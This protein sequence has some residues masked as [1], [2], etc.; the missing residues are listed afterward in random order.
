MSILVKCLRSILTTVVSILRKESSKNESDKQVDLGV[1]T[2]SK[3]SGF[4]EPENTDSEDKRNPGESEISNGDYCN[5]PGNTAPQNNPNLRKSKDSVESGFSDTQEKLEWLSPEDKRKLQKNYLYLRENLTTL[6]V[7][8][9][10]VSKEVF[11]AVDEMEIKDKRV[12]EAKAELFLQKLVHSKPHS[13]TIF[14]NAL[15]D[16]EQEFIADKLESTSLNSLSEISV[17][18]SELR[19]ERIEKMLNKNTEYIVKELHPKNIIPYF[20]VHEIIEIEDIEDIVYK[21]RKDQARFLL[22]LI[23]RNLPQ[24]Y[25]VLLYSLQKTESESLARKLNAM[26][27]ETQTNTTGAPV[28]YIE[29]KIKFAQTENEHILMEYLKDHLNAHK[30]DELGKQLLQKTGCVFQEAVIGS[31]VLYLTPCS[32][33]SYAKLL[34]F[35]KDGRVEELLKTLLSTDRAKELLPK[36]RVS[37][38]IQLRA[39]SILKESKNKE[40]KCLRSRLI[41][42]FETAVDEIDPID[43]KD[44]FIKQA[45]LS[46]EYFHQLGLDL[47]HSRSAR[48]TD[49]L[50]KVL[51]LGDNAILAFKETVEK[52]GPEYLLEVLYRDCKREHDN[53]D[54]DECIAEL[55]LL[56]KKSHVADGFVFYDR[57]VSLTIQDYIDLEEIQILDEEECRKKPGKKVQM[58]TTAR[59]EYHISR[60]TDN[61]CP[62]SPISSTR[63]SSGYNSL[64][65]SVRSN[66]Q[67]F[68][69]LVEHDPDISST[70]CQMPENGLT[71]A[72]LDRFQLTTLPVYSRQNTTHEPLHGYFMF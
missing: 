30:Q 9:R 1:S 20:V 62:E 37:I 41:E 71:T 11:K 52:K 43:F 5:E 56:G 69:C 12:E 46:E 50:T 28:F 61:L 67:L 51:Q 22:E 21:P 34:K 8:R 68:P 64:G 29:L 47:G 48:A 10:L 39:N 23:L 66:E 18:L 57:D 38:K 4:H 35:C 58:I 24:A 16:S 36:G 3:E 6:P 32:R 45:L 59:V 7:T 25:D 2:D 70:G 27:S 72:Y 65:S 55:E 33:E 19:R 31:L 44:S 60:Q 14:L 40:V 53:H 42:V 15:R 26:V 54:H 63:N 13:Y 49:F 17:D